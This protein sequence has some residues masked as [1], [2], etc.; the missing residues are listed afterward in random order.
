MYQADLSRL[1]VAITYV[2]RMSQGKNPVRNSAEPPD[3]T[4]NNP[5]V[6]RCMEYVG[7]ILRQV[8]DNDGV[9]GGRPYG[10]VLVDFPYEV[11]EGFQYRQDQGITRFLSQLRELA[12]DPKVKGIPA[13]KVTDWL[14]KMGYM[15]SQKS[16]FTGQTRNVVTEKGKEFGLYTELRVNAWG[17]NYEGVIYSQK[18]QEY[19]AAH[20]VEIVKGGDTDAG[21]AGSGDGQENHRSSD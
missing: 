20:M 1:E 16:P 12:G 11:L 15:E 18:A 8:R 5:N 21:T 17:Q 10:K 4:L 3:S 19:L 6:V 2:E 13:R 14:K 9:I 7:E